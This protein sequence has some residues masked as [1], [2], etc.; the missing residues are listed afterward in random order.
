M[1]YVVAVA[2]DV[3]LWLPPKRYI[4][5]PGIARLVMYTAAA[6]IMAATSVFPFPQSSYP[7]LSVLPVFVPETECSASPRTSTHVARD[8]LGPSYL[9]ITGK[10]DLDFIVDARYSLHNLGL[11]ISS[12]K[13][14]NWELH[15]GTF[16]FSEASKNSAKDECDVRRIDKISRIRVSVTALS[17]LRKMTS[18]VVR[19]R[20]RGARKDRRRDEIGE[21]V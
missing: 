14:D 18:S 12:K 17:H 4:I 2:Y 6:T 13:Q 1:S 21:D 16:N 9:S 10:R 19:R 20:L 8:E 3:T 5:A 15:L 11:E 7:R